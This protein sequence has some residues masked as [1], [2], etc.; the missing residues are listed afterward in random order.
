M[1]FPERQKTYPTHTLHLPM[2]WNPSMNKKE[3]V[4]Q[5]QALCFLCDC[6]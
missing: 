2:A 5:V 4:S 1:E 6:G 3:R